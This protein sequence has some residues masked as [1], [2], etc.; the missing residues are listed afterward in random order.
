MRSDNVADIHIADHI[1]RAQYHFTAFASVYIFHI[2]F[3]QFGIGIHQIAKAVVEQE[4]AVVFSAE[5][6]RF[7]GP[8]VVCKRAGVTVGKDTHVSY[9][10][11]Y[12]I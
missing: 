7:S 8:Q 12:K 2:V 10:C 5:V 4:K 11:V 3:Y 9:P 1:R 6:P